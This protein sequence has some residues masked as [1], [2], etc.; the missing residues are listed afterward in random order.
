MQC[1]WYCIKNLN[2]GKYQSIDFNSGYPYST[3][4]PG[5]IK[6]YDNKT[7]AQKFCDIMNSPNNTYG[8]FVVSLIEIRWKGDYL[9]TT[10]GLALY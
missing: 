9:D 1:T 6:F 3:D 10:G 7:D 4:Y 5:S 8:K 2:D